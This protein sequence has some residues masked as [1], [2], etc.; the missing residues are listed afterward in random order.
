MK[1]TNLITK[2]NKLFQKKDS[3]MS[4]AIEVGNHI[5]VDYDTHT[6]TCLNCGEV[7]EPPNAGISV[8]ILWGGIEVF[9][10]IHSNCLP[11]KD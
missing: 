11:E 6:T 5:L 7:E 4:K 3:R 9:R 1:I 2:S 10:E 8:D